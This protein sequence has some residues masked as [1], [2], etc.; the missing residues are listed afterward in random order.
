MAK[1]QTTI[2]IVLVIVTIITSMFVQVLIGFNKTILNPKYYNKLIVKHNLHDLPQNYVLVSIKETSNHLLSEPICNVLAPSINDAFSNDWIEYQSQSLIT[3][4]TDYIKGK[5]DH[6]DLEIP[7][8][9][10]KT[11]LEDNITTNLK[12]KYTKEELELFEI[13]SAEIIA[14]TILEGTNW[15]NSL[16]IAQ[17]MGFSPPEFQNTVDRFK[18]YYSFVKYTPYVLF[19]LFVILLMIVGK[20]GLGLKWLGYGVLVSALLTILTAYVAGSLIDDYL[21][22]NISKPDNIL[23]SIT[24][25]PYIIISVVKNS[26]INSINKISIVFGSAGTVLLIGRNLWSRKFRPKSIPKPLQN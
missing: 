21:L 17:V 14:S 16:N 24:S 26:L 25:N 11:V 6:L 10:R 3:Q 4:T 1:F 7:L 13:E 18:G 15:P 23:I 19:L 12:N 2:L 8:A 20:N 9:G 5:D 22:N